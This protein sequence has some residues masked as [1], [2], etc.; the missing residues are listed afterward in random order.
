MDDVVEAIARGI[1]Q[2]EACHPDDWQHFTEQA[3]AALAAIE[4]SG[5][6]V[7]PAVPTEA[8]IDAAIELEREDNE[9]MYASIY[10][11]MIA[12]RGDAE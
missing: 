10:T 9:G 2:A 4:A 11:A 8:M 5:R 3:Q 7:V 12:A 6:V 1:A